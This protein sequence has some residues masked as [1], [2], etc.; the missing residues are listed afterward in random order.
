IAQGRL[1]V[2]PGTHALLATDGLIR[3]I[4]IYARHDAR[5]LFEAAK[6]RGL[7]SLLC[8]LRQIE[9]D[10]VD[11]TAHPRVKRSDDATGILLRFT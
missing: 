11:C 4:D 6:S 2:E 8:E 10:D 3:L 9:A 1:Y 7:E 5:S